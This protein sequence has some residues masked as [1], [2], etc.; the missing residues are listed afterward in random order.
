MNISSL[1]HIK[2]YLSLDVMSEISYWKSLSLS[3]IFPFF[4]IYQQPEARMAEILRDIFY[5]EIWEKIFFLWQI[6][7][8][9]QAG[10]QVTQK[11]RYQSN[12]DSGETPENQGDKM[13]RKITQHWKL[14]IVWFKTFSNW[15]KKCRPTFIFAYIVYIV[16]NFVL[17]EMYLKVWLSLYGMIAVGCGLY[18]ALT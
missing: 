18:G 11:I 12:I 14:H 8:L 1:T 16:L 17:R 7:L 2:T 9:G 5:W 6:C 13:K 15:N 10:C 4:Q 3:F